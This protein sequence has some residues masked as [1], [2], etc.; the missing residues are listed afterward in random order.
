MPD[1]EEYPIP[2]QDFYPP[3]SPDQQFINEAFINKARLLE[4]DIKPQSLKWV[5]IQ[6]LSVGAVEAWKK[7]WYSVYDRSKILSITKEG[8]YSQNL[9]K[10]DLRI[11]INMMKL[12]H[13]TFD[14]D[15]PVLLTMKQATLWDYSHIISRSDEGYEIERQHKFTNSTESQSTQIIKDMR[16][17][18]RSGGS[19]FFGL[20]GR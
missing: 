19:R 13:E 10:I 18:Q 7:L 1:T 20:F 9:S 17:Q 16:P 3:S 12:Q 5:D 14:L 11:I 6:T 2:E 15:N 8:K 4:S